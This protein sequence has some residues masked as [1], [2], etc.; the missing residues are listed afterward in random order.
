MC[1]TCQ[2]FSLSQKATEEPGQ[3]TSKSVLGPSAHPTSIALPA[4]FQ[5]F[6][7]S[8]FFPKLSLSNMAFYAV[9]FYF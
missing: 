4:H 1:D 3:E 7:P 6:G 9:I 5:V 2:A 8:D